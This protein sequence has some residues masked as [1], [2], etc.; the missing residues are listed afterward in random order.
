MSTKTYYLSKEQ[1]DEGIYL[2][3]KKV[4]QILNDVE[5]LCQNNGDETSAVY[6]Y[7]VAVEEF[8]KSLLLE[9]CLSEPPG[10]KGIPVSVDLFAGSK[11]HELKFS[12]AFH[13]LP[14]ECV[15]YYDVD[16]WHEKYKIPSEHQERLQEV[17]EM[18]DSLKKLE[19]KWPN[20]EFI[21]GSIE[22]GFDFPIRKTLLYVNWDPVN[23]I[24]NKDVTINPYKTILD[25]NWKDQ[26]VEKDEDEIYPGKILHAIESFRDVLTER[27]ERSN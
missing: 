8:G 23:E 14:D 13:D 10:L 21:V 15:G 16:P 11:A 25:D 22:L 20:S 5:I 3:L 6:L 4:E 9:E 26:E 24:W 18:Q 2:C 7:T 19:K 27:S 12:R 1:I 17:I